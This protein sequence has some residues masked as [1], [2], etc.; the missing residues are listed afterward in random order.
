MAAMSLT[1]FALL[2]WFSGKCRQSAAG[3]W[4]ES[5]GKSRALA[6]CANNT[7]DA[8]YGFIIVFVSYLPALSSHAVLSP[9]DFE[10]SLSHI[11]HTCA[12]GIRWNHANVFEENESASTLGM[13][14][15]ARAN[16]C[17]TYHAHF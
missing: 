9:C 14:T 4:R 8:E 7:F 15:Y 10:A 17:T 11:L 5:C 2:H 12:H 16:V 6:T 3:K 13:P 1:P